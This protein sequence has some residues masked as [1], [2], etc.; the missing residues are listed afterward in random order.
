MKPAK[1]VRGHIIDSFTGTYYFRVY[2]NEGNFIDYDLRH[3]DLTVIIDDDDAVLYE[4]AFGAK[5]DHSPQTL[6]HNHE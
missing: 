3:H 1:G 5:L 2:D 4:D 6:G